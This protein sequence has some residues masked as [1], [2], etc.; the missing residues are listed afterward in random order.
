MSYLKKKTYFKTITGLFAGVFWAFICQTA[1]ASLITEYNVVELVNQTREAEGLKALEPDETLFKIASDKAS[2]MFKY[3]YFA[4]TSPQG[5]T[6][7]LWFEKNAYDYKYAGENL[8]INFS[9]AEEQQKAWMKSETHRQNI[10]DPNFTEIGIAVK[11]GILDG[12]LTTLTVQT[13]GQ[14]LAYAPPTD[15]QKTTAT[16]VAGETWISNL[17]PKVD[18]ETIQN[19]KRQLLGSGENFSHSMVQ[20]RDEKLVGFLES[21]FLSILW[22]I[23]TMNLLIL[24]RIGLGRFFPLKKMDKIEL[25]PKQLKWKKS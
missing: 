13:F 1:S 4:H 16:E 10:L 15:L 9:S 2:D 5:I 12:H 3:N 6:P 14:K 19:F 8:A 20:I 25:F 18:R 7:W 17:A 22:L 23:V 21:F 11:K 24:V